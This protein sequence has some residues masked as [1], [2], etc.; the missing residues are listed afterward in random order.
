M[1]LTVSFW[2]SEGERSVRWHG[3]SSSW[4]RLHWVEWLLQAVD[5]AFLPLEQL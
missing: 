4:R 2:K 3:A 1:T 5:K